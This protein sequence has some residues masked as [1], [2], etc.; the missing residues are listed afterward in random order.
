MVCANAP[1]YYFIICLDRCC[2]ASSR[3]RLLKGTVCH[4][5]LPR[6]RVG[7][8]EH[9][10][11]WTSPLLKLIY[12]CVVVHYLHALT[13]CQGTCSSPASHSN[14]AQASVG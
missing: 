12:T 3:N 9:G 8:S 11:K 10:V 7:T 13:P 1:Q 4:L 14:Q 2:R 6:V 5:R